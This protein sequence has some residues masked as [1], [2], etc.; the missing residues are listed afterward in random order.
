MPTLL[1]KMSIVL[2]VTTERSCYSK[3]RKVDQIR[4]LYLNFQ[5]SETSVL[6]EA[7]FVDVNMTGN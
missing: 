7:I 4:R 1:V 5:E 3:N 6:N 2:D